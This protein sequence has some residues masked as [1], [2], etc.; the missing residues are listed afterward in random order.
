MTID[1]IDYVTRTG[2][3]ISS[4]HTIGTIWVTPKSTKMH[5]KWPK[6]TEFSNTFDIIYRIETLVIRLSRRLKVI[7]PNPCGWY[8]PINNKGT[9]LRTQGSLTRKIH[10]NLIVISRVVWS[11]DRRL[12]VCVYS[13]T[14]HSTV[15]PFTKLILTSVCSDEKILHLVPEV[16]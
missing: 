14:T 11:C 6:I 3:T 7:W 12:H 2:N 13:H 9:M 16:F 15:N 8:L 10:P 4:I 5:K 1:I